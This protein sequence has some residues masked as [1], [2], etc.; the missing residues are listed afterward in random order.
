[1]VEYAEKKQQSMFLFTARRGLSPQTV[2]SDCHTT[3]TCTNCQAPVV[4]HTSKKIGRYFLCH[5]CGK[6]RTALEACKKCQSWNLTTLGIGS[7]SVEQELRM[8]YPHIPVFRIDRDAAKSDSEAK[9]I[10]HEF[11]KHPFAILVGTETALS[12]IETIKHVAVVSMESLFSIPD[13]RIH[14]RIAHMYIRLLE[15]A[16]SYLLVQTRQVDNIIIKSLEQRTFSEYVKDELKMR[17]LLQYPPYT[18]MAKIVL[19][20]TNQFVSAQAKK[21]QDELAEYNPQVFPAMIPSPEGPTIHIL[22]NLPH[23]VWNSKACVHT[24]LYRKL[25]TISRIAPI[26][27]NPESFI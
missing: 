4:L 22:F 11:K 19:K 18:L 6:E 13:F 15:V 7:D 5:H 21:I 17:E 8:L 10:M 14:E 24:E 27:V 1:M 9:K 12:Y 20:G 26:Q 3:V 23:T 25:E 16:E 2:C